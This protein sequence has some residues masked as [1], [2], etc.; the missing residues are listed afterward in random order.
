[1]RKKRILL[2][3]VGAL[4]STALWAQSAGDYVLTGWVKDSIS[5][6]SEAYATIR[7]KKAGAEK[8]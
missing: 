7:L 8:A 2:T 5:G 3:L 6:E 1:M 4:L